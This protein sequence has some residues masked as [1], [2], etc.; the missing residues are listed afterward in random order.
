[1]DTLAALE[2]VGRCVSNTCITAVVMKIA[3]VR[4]TAP[5]SYSSLNMQRLVSFEALNKFCSSPPI[6][7]THAL[8]SE[9]VASMQLVFQDSTDYRGH[10]QYIKLGMAQ[11][12][13]TQRHGVLL[14]LHMR[15]KV[16][17]N[18]SAE[19]LT[20]SSDLPLQTRL[21][22][23]DPRDCCCSGACIQIT[24]LAKLCRYYANVNSSSIQ[25][26]KRLRWRLPH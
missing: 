15:S 11:Q 3:V 13:M 14:Q 1:M 21:V 22:E 7:D 25:M 24:A 26:P 4:M 12:S 20:A 16:V 17:C 9:A 10:L 19:G 8:S 18:Q 5:P 6:V 2:S 23:L